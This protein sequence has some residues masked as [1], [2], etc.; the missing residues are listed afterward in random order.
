MSC[1]GCK[2]NPEI[3][4][5]LVQTNRHPCYSADAHH[6]YARMHLPVAP[7]CNI[8][9][10]YCNRKFD[11]VNESRP[12][13]TSEILSPEE[14]LQK[15]HKVKAAIPNLSVIGIAG[16]GDALANWPKTR[17]AIVR[18]KAEDDSMIFCLSTNGLLL[19]DYME[20]IVELDVKHVTVTMNCL[21]AAIGA[22]IY[23]HIYY[24]EKKYVGEEAARILLE[25]QLKGITWL[26]Q[27]GVL[28]KVNM[29]MI[30]GINDHH[31]PAV[32]KRV[33]AAGA[34]IANIMPL[35]PASGS[36][37]QDYPQTSM[38]EIQDMRNLCEVDIKQMKHCRQCR[39]DAIGMLDYDRSEEFRMHEEPDKLAEASCQLPKHY[40]VAVTSK[41]GKLVD[42]HFGHA[43]EFLIYQYINHKFILAEAR[44]VDKYCNGITEC[45]D[46]AEEKQAVIEA[47]ADCDA[48]LTMRIGRVPQKKLINKG[49]LV[50]E[51]CSTVESGLSYALTQLAM[52][53]AI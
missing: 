44:S 49:V 34:F 28:V 23:K 17:E 5:H 15:F 8:S 47:I 2:G 48:V 12:G 33:K 43:S 46:D 37:F 19:P 40:T 16:P 10:N 39:A 50:L 52:K 3:G 13:V 22:K 14:A 25:N 38:K 11:C 32:A 30:K 26:A 42:Q 9:C 36:V 53:E 51:Y 24:R 45:D 29:V 6:K 21:D 35:I 18:I 20:E 27:K 7:M 4:N 1:S 31:I 41:H